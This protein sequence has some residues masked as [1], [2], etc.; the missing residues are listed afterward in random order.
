MIS[1]TEGW[2]NIST[3]SGYKAPLTM[4]WS[5][6]SYTCSTGQFCPEA[7]T[8]DAPGHNPCV[9]PNGENGGESS[10]IAEVLD[11]AD[12]DLPLGRLHPQV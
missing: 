6:G 8:P 2:I 7:Y 9:G 4:E 12:F 3:V 11:R 1:S 10:A 5:C